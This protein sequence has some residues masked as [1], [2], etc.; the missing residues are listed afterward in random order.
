M[1][2][3]VIYDSRFGNTEKIAEQIA[4]GVG[5]DAKSIN[6]VKREDLGEFELIVAGSPTH[7]G[8]PS[9][10]MQE[11]LNSI[12]NDLIKSKKSASFDT[13]MPIEGQK[14]LLK[15]II[16]FFGYA[17]KR[18]A[19]NLNNRGAHIIATESFYVLGKEGPLK[20][21]ELKRAKH[22]GTG[23]VKLIESRRG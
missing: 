16:K 18:I 19:D 17:A 6:N 4:L 5:C 12:N 20:D 3:L 10:S 22:W 2:A 1:K 21:G 13:S 23:L 7:G 8:R 14:F 9:Q 15:L 11:F